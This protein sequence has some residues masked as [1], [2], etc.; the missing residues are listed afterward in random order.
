MGEVQ[1]AVT[2]GG[3]KGP[4]PRTED[5]EEKWPPGQDVVYRALFRLATP[6]SS[7]DKLALLACRQQGVLVESLL[8]PLPSQFKGGG[9]PE[10]KQ[11]MHFKAASH[12]R[13][14]LASIVEQERHR[15]LLRLFAT[16]QGRLRA[17]KAR[18]EEEQVAAGLVAEAA[19]QQGTLPHRL[20]RNL[21]DEASDDAM[22]ESQRQEHR[23]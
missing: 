18:R 20:G 11:K 1:L 8:C 21:E 4:S 17:A 3:H 7:Y 2:P 16:S 22:D 15:L 12:R 14:T 23:A 13:T 19:V 10:V 5:P 9:V 6:T